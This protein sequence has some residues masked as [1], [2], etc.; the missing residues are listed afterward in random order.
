MLKKIIEPILKCPYDCKCNTA[1]KKIFKDLNI[2]IATLDIKKVEEKK[3]N[4]IP[5]VNPRE[6]CD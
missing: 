6:R 1:I 3:N 4:N 5:L 2:N